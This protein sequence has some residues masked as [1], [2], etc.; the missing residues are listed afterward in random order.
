[1]Q[2]PQ[3]LAAA[4]AAA[5][6]FSTSTLHTAMDIAPPVDIKW[7]GFIH[8]WAGLGE[9]AK[10]EDVN[11][12][13]GLERLRFRMAA[14]PYDGVT[15]VIIPELAGAFSLLD[16]Y[17]KIDLD[18]YFLD[19]AA[20]P[21]S[22]TAGQFKTP[23]GQNRMY[24]PPQ[25]A[26]VDYSN[27]YNGAGGVVQ[28][29][30]F[31]DQGLM[32]SAPIDTWAKFD[33]AWVH[34]LGPNQVAP[35]TGFGG[36]QMQDF[37]GILNLTKLYPGLTVGGSFYA[38]ESFNPAGLAAFPVNTTISPKVFSG[39]HFKYATFG[40][41]FSLEAEFINRTLDRIGYNAVLSQY[42]TD[43]WQLVY[44]YD[45]VTVYVNDKNDHTRHIV[46]VNWFP[47]GTVRVSLNQV[48]TRT[49]VSQVP[50]N[51][52]TILQTQVTW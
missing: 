23:F 10:Q 48:G 31:W 40:K 4:L 34:G 24:T 43:A 38:G 20:W 35:G 26:V 46:G 30:S 2:Y 37:S 29:T 22:V 5:L 21:I 9:N 3:R 42:I 6:L 51:T 49:G 47:G 27:I 15:V 25:L 39:A 12:G 36:K 17:A 19:L 50:G 14:S 44:S 16:G 45:H 33:L 13:V 32:V 41:G 52:A 1:M 28:A 7:N 8:A 18:K 11:A